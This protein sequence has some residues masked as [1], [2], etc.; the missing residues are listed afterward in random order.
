MDKSRF[1]KIIKKNLVAESG[2]SYFGY[3]TSHGTKKYDLYYKK[4]VFDDFVNEMKESYGDAY[5][6]YYEG[7]G[8]EL[9]PHKSRY[10]VL[11]PKMACVASSSRFCYLAFRDGTKGIGLD[12][13]VEFEYDCRIKGIAGT[14]PQLD[15]YISD[16]NVFIEV[17]CHEIFDHHSIRMKNVYWDLIY[18]N[19]NQFGFENIEHTK[20][21]YFDIPLSMFGIEKEHSMFDIKQLLC[22]L[23]GIA[24]HSDE[25][26]KLVFLFYWPI[27]DNVNVNEE[28]EF[29]FGELKKEINSIF[30]SNPIK[31]FCTANNI[32]V[33]AV[34]EKS[35]M[36]EALNYNNIE[37][38]YGRL[39]L[40]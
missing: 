13:K 11:P 6:K 7:K 33:V 16:R 32:E 15:A 3:Q 18:G 31:M 26:K 2:P 19:N 4:E 28:I 23:L 8:S 36:M 35:K 29:V 21:D 22:H 5:C 34:V 27:T 38:L 12:G 39:I 24:C 1:D 30:N 20:D 9:K 25:S 17:K 10:G 37:E 14:A 40:G